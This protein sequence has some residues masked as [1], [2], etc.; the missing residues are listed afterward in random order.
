MGYQMIMVS[1]PAPHVREIRLNRPDRLNAI[2][3]DIVGELNLALDAAEGDGDV[4]VVV[5]SGEGRAF[6]AG[7]NYK[8][9][10]HGERTMFQK[11][12]YVKLLLE[13]CRRLNRFPRP[14]IA[15]VQGYAVGVGAEM[16]LNCDF[17]VMAE[18]AELGFPE[19]GIA[20]MVGGAVTKI[21]P[22]LVGLAKAREMIMLCD[23]ITGREAK[24]LGLASRC[25]TLASLRDET[26]ALAGR[27]AERAPISVSLAKQLINGEANYDDTLAI[28][29]EAVLTCMMTDDWQEGVRAFAER[30]KPVFAGR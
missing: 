14:V 24:S 29:R 8:R 6:C 22:R 7:A 26:L 9:H 15:A 30:R 10:V 21:L 1:D 27:L 5:L 19:V 28:E 17:I 25:V 23:R 16:C 12:E 13:T 11:R 3:E 4:R 18:D 2:D 20:T